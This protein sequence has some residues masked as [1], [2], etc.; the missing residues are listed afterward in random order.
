MPPVNNSEDFPE[1]LPL[2]QLRATWKS[3]HDN[4]ITNEKGE[5]LFIVVFDESELE[6]VQNRGAAARRIDRKA[7]PFHKQKTKELIGQLEEEHELESHRV[8]STV[9][10]G[11]SVYLSEKKEKALAKDKRI[12]AMVPAWRIP[13]SGPTWIDTS[14]TYG[15]VFPWGVQSFSGPLPRYDVAPVHILDS[16]VDYNTDLNVMFR[17]SVGGYA[18]VGCYQHGT[19]IAGIIG[20]LAYNYRGTVGLRPNTPISSVAFNDAIVPGLCLASGTTDAT[21][22]G[23]E[24]VR[25]QVRQRCL[26]GD[27]RP[28][29]MNFSFNGIGTAN[30][31]FALA[32]QRLTRSEP[33]DYYPGTLVIHSAGNQELPASS[34]TIASTP[35]DGY[36]RVGGHDQNG[37]PV[38]S[39]NRRPGF[40]NGTSNFLGALF[41]QD[42][43][44]GSNYGEY[45]DVWAPAKLIKSTVYGSS[46]GIGSG[47]SFAA[48]HIAALAASVRETL[49]QWATPGQL[50]QALRTRFFTNGARDRQNLPLYVARGMNG[51]YTA[52]PTVEFYS[53]GVGVPPGSPPSA[54]EISRSVTTAQPFTISADAVGGNTCNL[55]A[56]WNGYYWF[57]LSN[58]KLPYTWNT[59]PNGSNS[60]MVWQ[61]PGTG[62]WT[63]TCWDPA[64]PYITNTAT[65]TVTV[66]QAPPLPS[67]TWHINGV[68]RTNQPPSIVNRAPGMS[69]GTFTLRFF[70]S[71]ATVSRV[72]G[73]Y[74][75]YYHWGYD[76]DVP[77]VWYADALVA[78]DGH[79]W[80]LVG[81]YP[82]KY[83]WVATCDGRDGRSVSARAHVTVQ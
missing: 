41:S 65:A 37:Q 69:L 76:F 26:Q 31:V 75:G 78:S 59:G 1:H 50:E 46:V 8:H 63:L 47:T 12:K 52:K 72:T 40:W 64:T 29:I 79:N 30:Q 81:L 83:S 71:N 42:A 11:F 36:L 23:V 39:L 7:A 56:T 51:T 16:G 24:L 62:V 9:I 53:D 57:S 70:A 48:P 32:I 28:G 80:G 74:G 19:F 4:P 13:A 45:V 67:I 3:L 43:D 35:S 10:E 27:C 49:P 68:D 14:Y 66:T 6:K 77:T 17:S 2:K 60:G 21:L 18:P 5:K 54:A 20:A 61:Y 58:I 15:E 34:V 25:S 55:Y 73:Y 82:N 22:S 38:V 44:K 33:W